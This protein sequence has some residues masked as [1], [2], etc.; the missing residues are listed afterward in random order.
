MNINNCVYIV[1]S[2]IPVSLAGNVLKIPHELRKRADPGFGK[3]INLIE[4]EIYRL[5]PA[6]AKLHIKTKVTEC[7]EI[8]VEEQLY[9]AAI[10]L[11]KNELA[12]SLPGVEVKDIA[13]V[14]N[15]RELIKTLHGRIQPA[16]DAINILANEYE[17]TEQVKLACGDFDNNSTT[18]Y[19][20]S[21][22][23]LR[24]AKKIRKIKVPENSIFLSTADGVKE[25]VIG[26]KDKN[27]VFAEKD[28]R[29]LNAR[30]VDFNTFDKKL[31]MI[32]VRVDGSP[33]ESEKD[34][35]SKY[36]NQN[37]DELI[38]AKLEGL[39]VHCEVEQALRYNS[40]EI[41]TDSYLM[42][43]VIKINS[44]EFKLN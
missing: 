44:P 24:I 9:R 42:V 3:F 16:M 32:E 35:I 5:L 15:V 20:G 33:I 21:E 12:E 38:R 19:V 31:S 13:S 25:A 29:L 28:R 27:A 43:N 10:T 18:I 6:K 11:E 41:A 36:P 30:I 1:S 4:D 34:F 26:V 39:V 7:L 40:G 37:E 14:I 8:D 17:N 22:D 23:I 2:H